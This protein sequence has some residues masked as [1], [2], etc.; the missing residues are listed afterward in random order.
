MCLLDKGGS[1]SKVRIPVPY[2]IFGDRPPLIGCIEY[3]DKAFDW[4]ESCGMQILIELHTVPGSQNVEGRKSEEMGLRHPHRIDLAGHHRRAD[5][6]HSSLIITG[7]G[8]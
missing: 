3:L 4:A 5:Q 8:C 2:F 7:F 6:S 1:L